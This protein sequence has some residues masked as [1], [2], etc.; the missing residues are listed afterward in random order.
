MF[1]NGKVRASQPDLGYDANR[2]EYGADGSIIYGVDTTTTGNALT[3]FEVGASGVTVKRKFSEIGL[4]DFRY[5]DGLLYRVKDI[6]S[7]PVKVVNPESGLATNLFQ[8]PEQPPFGFR[9]GSL[10]AANKKMYFLTATGIRINDLNTG[11]PLAF[12][13][14][15]VGEI[16]AYRD[17]TKFVYW[18]RRGVAIANGNSIDIFTLYKP[19]TP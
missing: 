6:F 13:E 18:G 4:S 19:T 12:Y 16:V 1:D 11:Q 15:P 3:V 17:L 2:I 8:F 10:D 9:Y 5:F 7:N 14:F